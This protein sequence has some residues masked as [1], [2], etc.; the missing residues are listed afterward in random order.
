MQA[1]RDG[2]RAFP[3][4]FFGDKFVWVKPKFTKIVKHVLPDK[5]VLYV[6]AGAAIMMFVERRFRNG[7]CL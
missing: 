1:W 6:K 4:M 7:C 2:P 3:H 5:K